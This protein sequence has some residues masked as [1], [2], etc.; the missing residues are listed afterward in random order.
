MP[1]FKNKVLA[2]N[3]FT[4]TTTSDGK[5]L[6]K[7]GAANI[8]CRLNSLSFHTSVA[9]DLS[10]YQQD[11]NDADNKILILE[12]LSTKDLY[13]TNLL[14]PTENNFSW[15]LV[16][17]TTTLSQDGFLTIDYDYQVTEGG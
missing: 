7:A 6:P 9:S 4:G 8:Q 14:L 3:Q 12:E 11:P 17:V 15:A 1:I 10:L 5:F 16:V 2:G 13:L